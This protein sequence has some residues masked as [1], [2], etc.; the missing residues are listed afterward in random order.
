MLDVHPP[1]HPTHTWR[2]FFIHI[3]TIVVGLLIAIALEQT[4]EFFHHRHQLERLD[5]ALDQEIFNNR[6]LLVRDTAILDTIIRIEQV[7]K[8]SLEAAMQPG[9]HAVIVYTPTALIE[10]NPSVRWGTPVG[11]VSATARDAGIL[12]LLPSSRAHYFTRLDLVYANVAELQHQLFDQEYHVRSLAQ[13]YPDINSLA[14]AQRDELLLA[15]S[16]FEQVAD[17]MRY[18]LER[19]RFVLDEPHD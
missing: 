19:I 3:A 15:V 9:S 8:A 16:Q 4:V 6:K 17:H 11:A 13:L 18:M 5:Q 2:D 1:H 12:A 7:N 10:S 14:P